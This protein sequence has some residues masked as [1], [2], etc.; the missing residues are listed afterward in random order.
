VITDAEHVYTPPQETN[1]KSWEEAYEIVNNTARSPFTLPVE[2]FTMARLHES[3]RSLDI[4][5]I[6]TLIEHEWSL[7]VKTLEAQLARIAQDTDAELW[8]HKTGNRTDSELIDHLEEWADEKKYAEKYLARARQEY[9]VLHDAAAK[10]DAIVA[11]VQ[12]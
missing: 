2:M 8:H 11:D 1:G 9:E 7:R 4:H 5:E 6:M 3:Q 12:G 10:L